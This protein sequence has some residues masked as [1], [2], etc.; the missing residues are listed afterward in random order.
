MQ[1]GPTSGTYT[2][3][4]GAGQKLIESEVAANSEARQRAFLL[5]KVHGQ[6]ICR[7]ATALCNTCPLTASCAFVNAAPAGKVK[8]LLRSRHN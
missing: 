2:R 6:S 1:M 4:Y 5:L 3:D 8:R 7:R